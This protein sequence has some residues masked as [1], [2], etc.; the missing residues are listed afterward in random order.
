MTTMYERIGGE[1]VVREL[2]ELFHALVVADDLIGPMFAGSGE[3]HVRNLA[4]FMGEMFGGPARYTEDRGGVGGLYDAHLRLG[5][6]EAQR[7]RFVELLLVAAREAGLPDDAGFRERFARHIEAGSRF[8]AKFS[9]PEVAEA[10]R[11]AF[12]PMAPWTWG[13]DDS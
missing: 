8:S 2:C 9:Q 12:P 6:T 13:E 10:P 7:E 11:P 5:I 1:P 3:S 4:K